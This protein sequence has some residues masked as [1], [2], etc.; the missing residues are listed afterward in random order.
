MIF[1][2]FFLFIFLVKVRFTVW[3]SACTFARVK[4]IEPVCIIGHDYCFA[5]LFFIS[6]RFGI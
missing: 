5:I 2:F 3:K 4:Y 6:S 1:L